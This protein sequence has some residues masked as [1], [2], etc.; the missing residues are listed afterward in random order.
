MSGAPCRAGVS[1]PPSRSHLFKRFDWVKGWTRPSREA[2]GGGGAVWCLGG[3]PKPCE[4][5]G[6]GV[7]RLLPSLWSVARRIFGSPTQVG[8]EV[9]S[10]MLDT[11]WVE[12]R[13]R[14]R[15][16]L[17]AKDYDTWIAP[18]LPARCSAD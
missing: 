16:E 8:L 6:R 3:R 11:I 1:A 4:R 9:G 2:G 14:L 10:G 5:A 13:R 7:G 18:L 12:A 17:L 15:S